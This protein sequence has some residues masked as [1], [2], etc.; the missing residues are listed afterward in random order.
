M[1][2]G[3]TGRVERGTTEAD[4]DEIVA[5]VIEA[6]QDTAREWLTG[7]WNANADEGILHCAQV[8]LVWQTDGSA[9][10]KVDDDVV[11][12]IGVSASVSFLEFKDEV[13]APTGFILPRT[14]STVPAGWFVKDPKGRWWEILETK[15]TPA[16]QRVA[17]RMEGNRGEWTRDPAGPVSARRGT[18]SPKTR[19][20]AMDALAEA[21]TTAVIKDGEGPMQS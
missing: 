13:N 2:S 1:L 5:E 14:W 8:R 15:E 4:R 7:S 3:D 20:D 12:R 6:V 11:A 17:M 10:V 9:L 18:L 16:G 19:D 21:F